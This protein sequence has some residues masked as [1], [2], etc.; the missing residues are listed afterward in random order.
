MNVD[1][2]KSEYKELSDLLARCQAEAQALRLHMTYVRHIADMSMPIERLRPNDPGYSAAYALITEMRENYQA[3]VENHKTLGYVP[4]ILTPEDLKAMH[5]G[6]IIAAGTVK[7]SPDEIY[8]TSDHIGRP[9]RYVAKRGGIHDWAIYL[10]WESKSLDQVL[11]HGQ[12]LQSLKHVKKLVP[13]TD[14]ALN[15]YR[16]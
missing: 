10:D 5:P 2:L 8:M 14:E 3:M 1:Q 13:C 12:K 4:K 11:D 9:M 6:A 16:L 7:N 15:L